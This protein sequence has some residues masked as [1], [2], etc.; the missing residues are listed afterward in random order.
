MDLI[1][2]ISRKTIGVAV[3]GLGRVGLP[4]ASIFAENG[5]SVIG[6]ENNKQRA[7]SIKKGISPFHDPILQNS[8]STTIK[9]GKFLIHE[10]MSG[11]DD[12][13][14]II[15]ISVG[16]PN[17]NENNIDY[18]QLYSALEEISKID[19]KNKI[20]VLRST[21]PPT[22][23]LEIVKPFF[24]K[25]FSYV[26]GIDFGLAMCPE[27]ILEGKAM[28][29]LKT[30][31]EIIG[32]I[33]DECNK[34][35]AELFKIINP[36][37][38]ILFTSPTGAEVAKLFANIY[39]YVSF[40]LS[41]ELAI[42]AEKY[43]L[44]AT[45]IINISNYNYSRSNI[46]QPGFVGGPCLTKD[47]TFLDNNTTF[48]SI[49][50][51]AWK[52]NE[53]IPQYIVGNLKNIVGNMFGKKIS[54]LGTSFKAGSDDQRNS[55]SLKLVEILKSIGC[56]VTIH[57]PH[58]KNTTSLEDALNS[59]EIVIIATNHKEFQSIIKQI[60]DSNCLVV[61]DVWSM[62]QKEDFP[63]IQYYRFGKNF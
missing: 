23:T 55:P 37:K 11:L 14:D 47:G 45:E 16:T 44:D 15:F 26:A 28:I 42:W 33:N 20:I 9:S 25:K 36:Q 8:L 48:S 43:G 18:S 31:P 1:P 7:D 21:L 2:K 17:S 59:P 58:I 10:S 24:E 53:S 22:T 56:D 4:L 63:N 35:L 52:L 54:V 50:S 13:I 3:L 60:N 40:S 29:E 51:T 41:N 57:D 46:P 5:V 34:N 62:Y 30:L 61:Y 12:K 32:G 6:I 39:R 27:R 49:I 38:D 19:I